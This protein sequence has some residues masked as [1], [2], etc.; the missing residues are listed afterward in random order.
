M[1]LHDADIKALKPALVNSV[2]VYVLLNFGK[3]LIHTAAAPR[4]GS[5]SLNAKF[6]LR[7]RGRPHGPPNIFERIDR[8]V[9]NVQF[10]LTVFTQKK[11]CSRLS[12]SEMQFYTENSRFALLSLRG[13]L[14]ATYTMFFLGSLESA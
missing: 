5:T 11:L 3:A 9:N 10:S 14:A 6:S 12:L 13:G 4:S 7:L 2:Y 1:W 8:P